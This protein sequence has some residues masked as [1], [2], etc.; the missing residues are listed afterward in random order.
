MVFVKTQKIQ[1]HKPLDWY[2]HMDQYVIHCCWYFRQNLSNCFTL[3]WQLSKALPP[4]DPKEYF[5]LFEKRI[6]SVGCQD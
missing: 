5:N 2:R 6:I 1:Q 3:L 4:S